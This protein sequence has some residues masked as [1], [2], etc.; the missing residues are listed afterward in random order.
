MYL[1]QPFPGNTPEKFAE[2]ILSLSGRKERV[3]AITPD[4]KEIYFSVVHS[5]NSYT[6]RYF[7]YKD[8]VWQ[9]DETAPFVSDYMS[10]KSCTEPF[11]SPDG[12][13]LFFTSRESASSSD[14]NYDIWVTERTDTAWGQPERLSSSINTGNGEWHPCVTNSGN[15]YFARNGNIYFSEFS[16][17]N[18]SAAKGLSAINSSSKDWDPYVDPSERY[19]IFKSDRSGGFGKMDNYISFWDKSINEWTSP[20]NLGEPLNSG[21]T[22]D[23]G[24]VSPDGKYMFFSRSEGTETDVYW[25]KTDF[26]ESL[27]SA[28][29]S[30]HEPLSGKINIYPNPAS[31]VLNLGSYLPVNAVIGY[32]LLNLN[33]TV[34]SQ[35]II[36]DRTID[37]S[38]IS[39]G[40]YLLKLVIE[41]SV[42]N[43]KVIV[44]K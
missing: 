2:D 40:V 21:L 22:D 11:I 18:Y 16:D 27:G 19:L 36:I 7:K 26:I 6:I 9:E 1:G 43:R 33:G 4:G 23:A 28:C 29:L 31:D 5:S 44:L 32:T 24:D 3:I 8:G 20:V 13:K 14:W 10:G 38:G 39:N 34:V 42:I 30:V 12:T 17:G 37:I 15:L 25:V 41:G 35:G